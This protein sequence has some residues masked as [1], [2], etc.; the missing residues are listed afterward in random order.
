MSKEFGDEKFYIIK[1]T[2]SSKGVS[3]GPFDPSNSGSAFSEL[4]LY[5]DGSL[6]ELKQMNNKPD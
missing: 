2:Y 3:E 1:Y 6:K 5:I 4:F